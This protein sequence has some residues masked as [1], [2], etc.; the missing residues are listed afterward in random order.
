A[1]TVKTTGEAEALISGLKKLSVHN[2]SNLT[3]HPLDV[4]LNYSHPPILQRLRAIEQL[5][6]DVRHKI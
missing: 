5:S 6:S 3:P 1:W 2:L 4:F